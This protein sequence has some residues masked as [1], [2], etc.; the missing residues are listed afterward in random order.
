VERLT[1]LDQH[2]IE[3]GFDGL[4]GDVTVGNGDRQRLARLAR[5]TRRRAQNDDR[6]EDDGDGEDGA[7]KRPTFRAKAT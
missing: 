5:G 2:P 4:K 6:Q 3:W 1:Q 7:T